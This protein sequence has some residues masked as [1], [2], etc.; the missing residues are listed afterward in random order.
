MID[1]LITRGVSE[2]YRMFTSR[3]EYRLTLRAD[4]ADQRLTPLGR[5]A[6]VVGAQRAAAHEEGQ[7]RLS[8]A[9]ALLQGLSLTSSEAAKAGLKVNQDGQRRSAFT[10]L[11]YPEIAPERL[12]EIWPQVAQISDSLL[13][14]LQAEALYSGY[15]ARQMADI[16]AFRK[17]QNLGLP[18]DLKYEE[19][20]SLSAELRQKLAQIKPQSLGQAARIE[21]MTPAAISAL[22]RHVKKPSSLRKA[23]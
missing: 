4:N 20:P 18:E 22:L 5:M 13:E 19:L 9:R 3:A 14:R 8:A 17:E 21:G 15:A 7:R 11:A 12:R 2:P 6:G 1:D 23:V 16:E 10:L